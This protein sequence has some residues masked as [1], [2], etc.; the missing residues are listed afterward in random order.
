MNGLQAQKAHQKLV[1]N[2]TMMQMCTSN[3]TTTTNNKQVLLNDEDISSYDNSIMEFM[4]H[5][6]LK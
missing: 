4:A 6:I 1:H 2:K 3:T 5:E